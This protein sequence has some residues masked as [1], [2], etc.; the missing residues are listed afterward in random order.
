MDS[1]ENGARLCVER[2]TKDDFKFLKNKYGLYLPFPEGAVKH[3]SAHID[4]CI[5][6]N[7]I[8]VCPCK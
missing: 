2:E 4:I 1:H 5:V 6:Y 7:P 3:S 8:C